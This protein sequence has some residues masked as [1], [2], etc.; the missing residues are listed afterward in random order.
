MWHG[1]PGGRLWSRHPL[2]SSRSRSLLRG[3]GLL[4]VL[5]GRGGHAEDADA[6]LL[7]EDPAPAVRQLQM[8]DAIRTLALVCH[9]EVFAR[10]QAALGLGTIDARGRPDVDDEVVRR[11]VAPELRVVAPAHGA[12]AG[13]AV[14]GPAAPVGE[15][16]VADAA[17]T[18]ALL[19]HAEDV[20]GAELCSRPGA[21]HVRGGA[22]V[23]LLRLRRIVAPERCE[24]AHALDLHRQVLVI[25]LDPAIALVDTGN[26]RAPRR[27]T[28][29]DR[30]GVL[31]RRQLAE[32]EG[33][34]W[35]RGL[36]LAVVHQES[37]QVVAA[38][39][40]RR[41]RGAVAARAPD[42]RLCC[43]ALRGRGRHRRVLGGLRTPGHGS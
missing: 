27:A 43:R 40:N 28:N 25:H 42:L 11:P 10:L 37:R 13:L 33:D 24:H 35:G 16:Q 22:D 5:R 9:P 34:A 39:G 14:E 30:P 41:C 32:A 7:V 31:V 15:P 2:G 26:G 12:H 23:H 6:G 3:L 18:P 36:Q 29:R 17:G 1:Q 21:V 19:R 4:Q 38:H 20:A 8:A